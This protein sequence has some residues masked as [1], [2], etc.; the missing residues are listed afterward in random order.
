[1]PLDESQRIQLQNFFN[2]SNFPEAGAV[3][4]DLD[5]TAIHEYEGRY[6]IP[7]SVELGLKK[8]NDLGRPIVINTLRFPLSVIRTFGKEW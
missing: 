4:T 6:S 2:Q 7:K 1:M 5:G 3:I 8:I